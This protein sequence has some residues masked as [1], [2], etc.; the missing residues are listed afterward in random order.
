MTRKTGKILVTGAT[1]FIGCEVAKQLSQ[2][3]YKPR[4]MI[5][6]P[7]RAPLLNALDAEFMQADLKQ[8]KS[9]GRILESIDTVIHLGARAALEPARRIRP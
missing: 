6:R 5:R 2:K 3:G 4:L 7:L 9:L 1:G 8:P